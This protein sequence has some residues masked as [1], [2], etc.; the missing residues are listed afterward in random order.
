ME[1]YLRII[2]VSNNYLLHLYLILKV[3]N[4][5]WVAHFSFEDVNKWVLYQLLRVHVKAI[6]KHNHYIIIFLPH[7]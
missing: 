6:C 3:L 2:S 7:N 4:K 1:L 5:Y